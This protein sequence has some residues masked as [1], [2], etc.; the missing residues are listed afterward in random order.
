MGVQSFQ[1]A[2]R[3]GLALTL[4]GGELTPLELTAAYAVLAN[5]GQRVP[6]VSILRVTRANGELLYEHQPQ[7]PVQVIDPRVAFPHQRYS[8]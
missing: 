8:G 6:P 4:G 2:D 3:Y 7:A 5:E 1:D